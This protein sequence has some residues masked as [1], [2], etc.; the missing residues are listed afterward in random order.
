[1][2]EVTR[3]QI[4][5]KRLKIQNITGI[6]VALM[7]GPIIAFGGPGNVEA[8]LFPVT[9]DTKLEITKNTEKEICWLVEFKKLRDS[10]PYYF[11][12]IYKDEKNNPYH[13]VIRRRSGDDQADLTSNTI[14]PVG[15][16][17]HIENCI[18]RPSKAIGKNFTLEFRSAYIVSH[19]LWH[20]PRHIS[21]LVWKDNN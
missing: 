21:P 10:R 8:A 2:P 3:L 13:V 11:S 16:T 15:E 14:V 7:F 5:N 6:I 12:W 4:I 19:H 1:M 17:V 9:S 20:V 18:T